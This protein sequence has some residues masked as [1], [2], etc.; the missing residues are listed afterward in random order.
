MTIITNARQSYSWTQPDITYH[1]DRQQW[2]HRTE[3]RLAE[4]PSL[5]FTPLP[6]GFPKELSS[7]LV[8]EGK[9]CQTEKQWVFELTS[10]HLDEIDA[11][12]KHFHGLNVPFGQISPATFPLPTLGPVLRNLARELHHGRGFFVL[13]TIP[14]DSYSKSDNVLVYSGVSSYVAEVRGLQDKNGGVLSHIKDLSQLYAK[15]AIGGPAYTTDKQVFHTDQGADI[16]SLFALEVAAEGGVSRISSSWRI[17]NDLAENR[18]DLIQTLASPWIVDEFGR[19]PPFT[20]R[21]LLYH[22]DGKVI[23]QYAR[24]YFTGFQGLPRSADIPPITEAQ[25]EALDAL[26]FLGEKYSLGLN[27][28]KGDIQYINNL[29]IFHARDGFLDSPQ[30]T[31]HLLR[32]WQR[33]DELAWTLP[34]PLKPLW[35]RTFDITPEK[36]TFAIEPVIRDVVQGKN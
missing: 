7:P 13:R 28:Q 6:D 9:D 10:T 18:P 3:K 35:K 24:R 21:P 26:H 8:W 36:Q 29:S 20:E 31:R 5:P 23:I 1:P 11:A 2:Q 14:V 16:V 25:A 27:F 34:E 32:L 30:K 4:D 17:Y 12:V 19:D 15:G 33:N 22:V